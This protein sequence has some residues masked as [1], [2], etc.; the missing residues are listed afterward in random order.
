MCVCVYTGNVKAQ[1]QFPSFE[2]AQADLPDEQVSE[3]LSID[4]Q[5]LSESVC[6]VPLHRRLLIDDSLL[7]VSIHLSVLQIVDTQ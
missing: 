5:R 2:P 3:F 7:D 4:C 1:Y 6:C